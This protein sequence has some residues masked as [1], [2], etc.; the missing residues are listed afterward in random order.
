M[1]RREFVKRAAS[2]TALTALS[3]SRILGAND[4]IGVALIGCGGRGRQVARGVLSAGNVEYRTMCD[5]YDQQAQEASKELAGGKATTAR[6]FRKVLAQK[7]IDA[8]HIATP[9]HWHA[10]PAVLACQAGKDVFIEKPMTLTIREGQAVVAAARQYKRIV[11]VGTQHRSAPHV[12]EAA[13]IAQ[14]GEVGDIYYVRVWNSGQVAPNL[15]APVPDSAPPEG[16]DWDMYLGPAPKVPFNRQR[17]TSTYRQFL[18]YSNGYITDFG[19]HRID[20]VYQIMNMDWPLTIAAAGG[21]YCKQ[22]GGDIPDVLHVTYEFPNFIME[23]SAVWTNMYGRGGGRSEGLNYYGMS[24]P[25]NRPH[26][27]AF[28]GTK[29]ALYVDRIGYE[30]F[31]ELASEGF[32]PGRPPA[33]GGGRRGGGPVSFRTERKVVQGADATELH[34]QNFVK[35]LRS[36]QDPSPNAE[37]GHKATSTCLL[38]MLAW[39]TGRKLK[40]DGKK[41]DFIGDAEASRLLSRPM[42]APWNLIRLVK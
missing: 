2:A 8:V 39:K 34:G 16:L 12:A 11:M 10:M 38:G 14:S 37:V 22:N 42:R 27:F 30:V 25:Y 20:S 36:R 28:F 17:F 18:D 9:D 3:A 5:V 26:G 35:F 4:R 41:Q 29:G 19:N 6:D 7:D 21:K 1:Q 31:P 23:Y 33:Q 32:M 15:A 40:W 13:R 24:G